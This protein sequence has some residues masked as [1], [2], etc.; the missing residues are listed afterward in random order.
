MRHLNN[1]RPK[2]DAALDASALT[3][4]VSAIA[5]DGEN[6]LAGV[7]S[8]DAGGVYLLAAGS[9]PQLLVRLK[10]PVAIVLTKGDLFVADREGQQIWQIQNYRDTPAAA[11]FADGPAGIHSPVGIRV[12]RDG[13]KLLVANSGSKTL[14][15]YDVASHSAVGSVQL[16]F[17][18]T[19]LDQ[20]NG[21]ALFLLRSGGDGSEPLYVSSGVDSPAVYFVPAGRGE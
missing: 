12:S 3:G 16:E 6:V 2:A 7:S 15:T 8:D 4:T 19:Q 10:N 21:D 18:P 14:D 20:L 17:T 1:A 9:S 5:T 11:L 13:Q